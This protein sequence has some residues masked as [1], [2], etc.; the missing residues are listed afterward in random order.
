MKK[1]LYIHGSY[2]ES[3]SGEFFDTIN[4]ANGRVI[5]SVDQSSEDDVEKAI[6]SAEKGQ[7]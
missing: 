3:N 7:Q 5:A 2:Y 1:H 6:V 4:P